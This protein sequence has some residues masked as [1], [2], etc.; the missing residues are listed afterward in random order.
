M[1]FPAYSTYYSVIEKIKEHFDND[2]MVSKTTYG[3]LTGIDIN[4]QNLFP[5]IHF[6]VLKVVPQDQILRFDIILFGMDLMDISKDE[7]TD[8]FWGNDN[9]IDILNKIFVI[10]MEFRNEL[11]NGVFHGEGIEL[12]GEFEMEPFIERFENSLAGFSVPF[13]IY[14][15]NEFNIC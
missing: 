11:V 2:S 7:I 10:L 15:P 9:S 14:V 6:N 4:K 13:S 5:L 12:T 8:D 3:Q 1:A